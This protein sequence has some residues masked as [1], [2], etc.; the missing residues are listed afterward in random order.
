MEGKEYHS[1]EAK[2]PFP[3]NKM[4]TSSSYANFSAELVA[5]KKELERI[6]ENVNHSL[7]KSVASNQGLDS[8][9]GSLVP[10]EVAE[11][12]IQQPSQG[13][14]DIDDILEDLAVFFDLVTDPTVYYGDGERMPEPLRT[15]R[16]LGEQS[17]RVIRLR[18]KNACSIAN[19]K[20]VAKDR[21]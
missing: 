3:R 20:P 4:T 1:V 16:W 15:W 19:N 14:E 13:D 2:P 5:V 18:K 6:D 12:T 21:Q 10:T 11:T 7:G 9:D 17:G 8:I